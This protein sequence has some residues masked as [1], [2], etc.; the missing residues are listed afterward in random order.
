MGVQKR[1]KARIDETVV[2]SYFKPW[3]KRTWGRILIVLA[4]LIFL[5]SLYFAY[6]LANTFYQMSQGK[7]YDPATGLWITE[8]EERQSRL[9]AAE[10]ISGDSP[11]LG[12]E[13][14]FIHV[15]AYESLTCPFCREDQANIKRMLAN[16]GSIVRFTTKDFPTDSL[17]PGSFEAHLAAACANEQ[18]AYW[19][20]RDVLYQNQTEFTKTNLK[21]F[22]VPL[23]IN[24]N[25]FNKCLDEE[26]YT[27]EIKQSW[28]EG[29]RIGVEGTPTYIIN[30]NLI[31]GAISYELW[32][33]IIG[34]IVKGE[35]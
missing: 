2:K 35:Y 18:G 27:Y 17:H 8:E 10:L 33:E 5:F 6:I 13:E 29:A 23:G 12:S 14:P 30:G 3:Y 19:Q 9:I 32:E 20:Y 16:F 26:K 34:F 31:P 28:A 7:I 1:I 25:D 11:W 21:S 15:V 24:M 22:A 4:V